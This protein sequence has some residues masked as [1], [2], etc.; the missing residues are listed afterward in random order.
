MI[1]TDAKGGVGNGPDQYQKE[2]AGPPQNDGAVER[3]GPIGS[4]LSG[5]ELDAKR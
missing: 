5:L 4:L 1:R 3:L 2:F